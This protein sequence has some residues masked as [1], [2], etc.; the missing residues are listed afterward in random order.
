MLTTAACRYNLS[1]ILGLP[2]QSPQPL[3]PCLL[4]QP[5]PACTHLFSATVLAPNVEQGTNSATFQINPVTVTRSGEPFH[6][7]VVMYPNPEELDFYSPQRQEMKISFKISWFTVK[8]QQAKTSTGA[9]CHQAWSGLQELEICLVCVHMGGGDTNTQAKEG[10][11]QE[12]NLSGKII[13]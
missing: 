10:A 5:V 6:S 7:L 11:L 13:T 1:Q 2:Q 4:C 9:K 3:L 8:D 12:E